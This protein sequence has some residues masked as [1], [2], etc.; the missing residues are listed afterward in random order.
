MHLLLPMPWEATTSEYIWQLVDEK[1]EG[2]HVAGLTL[3][4]LTYY[5]LDLT[6]RTRTILNGRQT[7]N[8]LN[9]NNVT[10]VTDEGPPLI[11]TVT[12]LLQP[13]DLAMQF[14]AET[15][16]IHEMAW[17]W[18]WDSGTRRGGMARAVEVQALA[19]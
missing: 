6:T 8:V 2:I 19:A 5:A 14:P 1:K 3:M 4:T 17:R 13:A 15:W 12:W 16:E 18:A 11:T 9:A 7:Q 10:I